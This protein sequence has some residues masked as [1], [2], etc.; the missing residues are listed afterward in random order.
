MKEIKRNILLVDDEKKFLD[1]ISDRIR[2]RGFEPLS[3]CSGKEA[4]EIAR[5]TKIY[6]AVVDLNMP[7]IKWLCFLYI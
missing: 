1:T 2:I 6:A 4:L 3:A 5:K 7:D